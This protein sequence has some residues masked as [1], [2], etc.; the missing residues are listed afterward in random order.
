M[1]KVALISGVSREMGLGYETARQLGSQGYQVIISARNFSAVE[2]L[3]EKLS[4]EGLEI[5]PLL[6]DITRDESVEQAISYIS[7]KFGKLDVLIN[8]AGAFFDAGSNPL[9]ADIEFMRNA[10][11]TNLFGA[12]RM[13]KALVPLLQKSE[14]PRIVNVSSGAGTFS[15]SVFGLDKHPQN[16]PVYALT[17]LALNGLTVKLAKQ[18][19]SSNIIINAVCPG[20]VAT[21]EG[22]AE[23]GARPVADGARGIVWAAMLPNDSISGRL[24]RDGVL[25]EW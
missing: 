7:E 15:D 1:K 9:E 18:L 17:K 3:A 13:I 5:H 12:W 23:W 4:G 21:Y 24:F 25:L 14:T 19:E 10:F 20:W 6:L 16:V 11:E 22:T 8:N 2:Q